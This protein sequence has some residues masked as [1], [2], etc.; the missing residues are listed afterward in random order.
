MSSSLE[1]ENLPKFSPSSLGVYNECPTRWEFTYIDGLK[2]KGT[3]QYFEL[4]SYFHELAHHMYRAIESGLKIGS[5]ELMAFMEAR[6]RQDATTVTVESA[7]IMQTVFKM[8]RD[9]VLR[10]SPKIDQYIHKIYGV[11]RTL[12]IRVTTPMGHDVILEG[13]ADLVYHTI[14]GG[15]VLRDHK[16]GTKNPYSDEQLQLMAQLLFYG[17]VLYKLTGKI[18]KLEL[19]YINSTDYKK[20][21]DQP[22]YKLFNLYSHTPSLVKIHAFWDYLLNRIDTI[23]ETPPQPSYGQQCGS[24]AFNKVC[25]MKLEGM[26]PTHYIMGQYDKSKRDY[27]IPVTW[28][29]RPNPSTTQSSNEHSNG[30]SLAPASVD[31]SF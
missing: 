10:Q 14:D 27:T 8:V 9:Y 3:K 7:Q 22:L 15:I 2:S 28:R 18:P 6:I 20:R 1:I 13:I 23:L 30:N 4:G 29:D 12:S 5:P 21:S 11:E 24:C 31:F 19:S 16:S 17:A 25:L 26:N